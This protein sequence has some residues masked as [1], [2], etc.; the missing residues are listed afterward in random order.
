MATTLQKG[1]L[2]YDPV[3][4]QLQQQKM[5]TQL[6]GQ[7]GSPYEKI[8][9]GLAQIGGT[10]FGGESASTSKVNILNEVKNKAF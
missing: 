9:L 8:G 3:E 7:A 2:G 5:W 4:M 1:L 10:L 6:Y